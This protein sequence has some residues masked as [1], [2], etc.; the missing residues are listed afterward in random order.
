M[1]SL[2]AWPVLTSLALALAFAPA[3]G[4]DDP[5]PNRPA[6]PLVSESSAP[7]AAASAAPSAAASST[8]V[9]EDPPAAP[10]ASTEPAA[11]IA[12]TPPPAVSGS[13]V[14][15]PRPPLG[16]S[17]ARTGILKPDEAE[18]LLPKGSPTRVTLLDAGAE[19]RSPTRY[20]LTTGASTG[21]EMGLSMTLEVAQGERTAPPQTIPRIA[22]LLD[23]VTASA[24]KDGALGVDATVK[25]VSIAEDAGVPAQIAERL[26]PH[27]KAIEGLALHYDVTP[28]GRVKQ[29]GAKMP[30]SKKGAGLDGTLSQMTQSL[31][32]MI[33]PFPDEAIGIGARWQV[34]SR[35]DSSG[36]E[37]VQWS[38]F[39]LKERDDKGVKLALEV[40]QAAAKPEVTPPNLPPGVSAKLVD[41]ASTGKGEST[42]DFTF[43]APRAATMAVDSKMT[44]SVQQA[45]A[46]AASTS[47]KSKMVVDMTRGKGGKGAAKSGS[48]VPAAPA[49]PT[50]AA[51]APPPAPAPATP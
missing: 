19:P 18:K 38:T 21:I 43:P 41:F 42:V 33:A 36:T 31:E 34:L 46:P 48:K 49:A 3:I 12:D 30:A 24:A 4:C 10:G 6:A 2:R 11:P 17:T 44:L 32:S 5:A 7:V 25:K 28:E 1:R 20:A 50:P 40:V 47:M 35:F 9:G 14:A 15:P 22:T 27:L 13:A 29:A 45:N 39:E 23:L 26:L 16:K 8:P 37:L 51:P